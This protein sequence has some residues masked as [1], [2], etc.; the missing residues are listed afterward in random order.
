M[1]KVARSI[2]T[3]QSSGTPVAKKEKIVLKKKKSPLSRLQEIK[4]INAKGNLSRIFVE[5]TDAKVWPPD[6]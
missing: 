2:R 6:A 1:H 5:R 3:R 4:L